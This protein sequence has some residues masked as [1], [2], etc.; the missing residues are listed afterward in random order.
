MSPLQFHNVYGINVAQM[1]H[2]W[3][4]DD[5]GKKG[6]T[7]WYMS[8][9]GDLGNTTTVTF[10]PEDR[11]SEARD[12]RQ[13]LGSRYDFI[14]FTRFIGGPETAARE[15]N[16]TFYNVL[17][18]MQFSV[19][20]GLDSVFA[21]THKHLVRPGDFPWEGAVFMESGLWVVSGLEKDEDALVGRRCATKLEAL[22]GEVIGKA[23][24][25]AQ[26]MREDGLLDH[27]ENQGIKYLNSPQFTPRIQAIFPQKYWADA[28]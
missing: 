2:D 14:Q 10:V 11:M 18:K 24:E 25:I 13:W 19:R 8:R 12:P 22:L 26:Q 9:Y 3:F 4:N 15:P 6:F 20:T 16:G 5:E 23:M 27:P 28:T 21:E 1:W 17:G 7:K